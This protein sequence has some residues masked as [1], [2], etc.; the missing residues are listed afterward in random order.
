[1]NIDLLQTNTLLNF[2]IFFYS[3]PTFK[4]KAI[5]V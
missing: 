2:R 1:M 4:P 5:Y 3:L